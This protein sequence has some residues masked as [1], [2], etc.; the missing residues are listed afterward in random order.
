LIYG[1]NYI[2]RQGPDWHWDKCKS[3]EQVLTDLAYGIPSLVDCGQGYLVLDVAKELGLKVFLGLWYLQTKTFF[4]KKVG[5]KSGGGQHVAVTAES[6]MLDVCET[7]GASETK[8][9]IE[10]Y[11]AHHLQHELHR[12]SF[13][14][15]RYSHH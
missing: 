1:L 8:K 3:R 4:C 2:T 5:P 15:S 11:A 14:G 10:T 6:T 13:P 9:G 12:S 7:L